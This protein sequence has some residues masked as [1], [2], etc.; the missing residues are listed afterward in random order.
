VEDVLALIRGWQREPSVALPAPTPGGV[1]VRGGGPWAALCAGCHGDAGE[2]RT[3]LSLNNPWFLETADD[4]FVE[5]A[6]RQGRRGTSMPGFDGRLSDVAIADLV[7][8]IRSWAVPVDGSAPPAYEPDWDR[9]VLNPSGPDAGFELRE[10]RY[11]AADDV[12][13]AMQGGQRLMVIDARPL[14]D[15]ALGHIEGAVG[16]PF[17][18]LEASLDRIPRDVFVVAYCGCPHAVSGQAVDRLRA[19]G[20]ERSAVLDEGWYVWRDRGYPSVLP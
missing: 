14:S 4:A 11:V 6:I 16:L 12:L 10:G 9:A 19:A 7:A 5:F 13:A 8:L 17:F 15:F 3:A 1:A 2:G 20:H 18:A